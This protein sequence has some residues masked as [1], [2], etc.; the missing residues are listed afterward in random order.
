MPNP[1]DKRNA[2]MP[3]PSDA[4]EALRGFER[5]TRE[6]ETATLEARAN[7][8]MDEADLGTQMLIALLLA[9]IVAAS[10]LAFDIVA[11]LPYAH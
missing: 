9:F 2:A 4:E 8:A 1:S 10:I 11:K 7:D 3:A 6:W 5:A